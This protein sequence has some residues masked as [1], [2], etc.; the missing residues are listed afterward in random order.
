VRAKIA[1][2]LLAPDHADRVVAMLSDL[3]VEVVAVA[4]S[5]EELQ[6]TLAQV[7]V[8]GL[9]LGAVD[10]VAL[11]ARVVD[12]IEGRP[13]PVLGIV[14]QE[15]RADAEIWDWLSRTHSK[16]CAR[17]LLDRDDAGA[18]RTLGSA[19]SELAEA[20][21][22]R[23]DLSRSLMDVGDVVADIDDL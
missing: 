13:I 18:R 8:R 16:V 15:T 19:M 7:S 23:R 17:S 21:R 9:V 6:R 4:N 1:I 12:L 2:G 11:K 10:P 5:L 3:S 20:A 22:P 14:D